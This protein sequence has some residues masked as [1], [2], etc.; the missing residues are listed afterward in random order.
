MTTPTT[1]TQSGQHPGGNQPQSSDLQRLGC[2][3][4]VIIIALYLAVS[5]VRCVFSSGGGPPPESAPQAHSAPPDLL[6]K[7]SGVFISDTGKARVE[8]NAEQKRFS[9]H[10]TIGGRQLLQTEMAPVEV[11]VMDDA[12]QVIELL[13]DDLQA[14]AAPAARV[15]ITRTSE[16]GSFRLERIRPV[17]GILGDF[18]K[19]QP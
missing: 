8:I 7:F 2:G 14:G 16:A 11:N 9:Y 5:M 18:H 17:G 4:L 6:S 13:G 3:C 1:P 12:G 19:L 15:R 10:T